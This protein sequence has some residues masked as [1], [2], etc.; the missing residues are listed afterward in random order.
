MAHKQRHSA[1]VRLGVLVLLLGVTGSALGAATEGGISSSNNNQAGN[2]SSEQSSVSSEGDP[3]CTPTQRWEK[4]GGFIIYAAMFCYVFYGFAI[5]CDEFFVPAL[6]MFCER[7]GMPDDF[8]GATLMGLGSCAPDV[9][10]GL[11]GVLILHTDVGAGTIVGSLLFNHLCILGGSILAV[12]VLQ[13][14]TASLFRETFFYALALGLLLLSLYDHKI[15]PYESSALLGLYVVFCVTCGL[16]PCMQRLFSKCLRRRA[17][18]E[19]EPLLEPA[20]TSIQSS[21]PAPAVLV[22]PATPPLGAS[23]VEVPESLKE[24]A[25]MIRSGNVQART[26]TQARLARDETSQHEAPSLLKTESQIVPSSPQATA[27][28]TAPAT[29]TA[30]ARATSLLESQLETTESPA[31]QESQESQLQRSETSSELVDPLEGAGA[32]GSSQ[33]SSSTTSSGTGAKLTRSTSGKINRRRLKDSSLTAYERVCKTRN[34]PM[35]S[36]ESLGFNYGQC[37]AHG[38]LLKKSIF[39]SKMRVSAQA[40]QRKWFVLD[41]RLWYCRNPLWCEPKQRR[42]IPLWSAYQC[43]ID[44]SDSTGCTFNLLTRLRVYTMRATTPELAVQW[45]R[46]LS[47][48][49][50]MLKVLCPDLLTEHG[51]VGV[52]D[53]EEEGLLTWPKQG[54]VLSQFAWVVGLPLALAWT[55]TIPNVKRKR[56]ERWYVLTFAMV[57]VWL[58]AMAYGMVWAASRFACVWGIPQDIMGLTITAI[59]ASFPSLFGSILAARQGSAGMAVSNAFGANLSSILVALGLP[60]FIAT[61]ILQPGVPAIVDSQS[62]VTSVVVLAGALGIFIVVTLVA[63]ARFSRPIGFFFLGLYVALLALVVCLDI[64]HINF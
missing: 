20:K 50:E 48:R 34:E 21:S 8:A 7:L 2:W 3:E 17:K 38:F 61:V 9:F 19:R 57:L 12:G 39:Y 15:T 23:S 49:I 6:N 56:W 24:I 10:S 18:G 5:I 30:Q 51:V 40:W 35:P 33:L 55:A 53:E 29:P 25:S 63:R 28:G 43:E 52:E 16:T 37:H 42:N 45:V 46:A 62:I 64:F 47:E 11:I 59:G 22:P 60:Y 41:D 32:A 27:A 31:E 14:E 26:P 54:N 4:K 44:G 13:V 58:A 36:G 1:I